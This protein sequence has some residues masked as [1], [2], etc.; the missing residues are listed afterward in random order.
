MEHGGRRSGIAVDPARIRAARLEAGLSLAQL[1]RDDVSR[2]FIHYIEMGRSRPSPRVL[3]L[4]ARRTRKPISYFTAQSGRNLQ[5]ELDLPAEL[6]RM[7][8][9]VREFNDSQRLDDVES[10]SMKLVE[11][12]LRQAAQVSMAIQTQGA[13]SRSPR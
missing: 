11:L 8:N 9:L 5:T 4:I 13:A 7:A 2:T 3:A 10:S 1:A 6:V 12:I